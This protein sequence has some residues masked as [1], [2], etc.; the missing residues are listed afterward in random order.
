MKNAMAAIGIGGGGG[1]G[2]CARLSSSAISARGKLKM[3][4]AKASPHSRAVRVGCHLLVF[5]EYI[6]TYIEKCILLNKVLR[7][8]LDGEGEAGVA[9]KSSSTTC[10]SHGQGWCLSSPTHSKNEK[11]VIFFSER[12]ELEAVNVLHNLFL[13]DYSRIRPL[14]SRKLSDTSGFFMAKYRSSYSLGAYSHQSLGP[15]HTIPL[16]LHS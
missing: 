8:A 10:L 2:R 5:I 16:I 15:E 13:S 7:V 14:F 3:A 12:L 4:K 1:G 11:N 9:C 6:T